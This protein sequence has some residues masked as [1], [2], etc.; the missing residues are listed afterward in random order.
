MKKLTPHLLYLTKEWWEWWKFGQSDESDQFATNECTD[1][2]YRD[3]KQVPSWETFFLCDGPNNAKEHSCQ[4][5]YRG[6]Q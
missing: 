3:P 1:E 5:N 6:H 4:K 2:E